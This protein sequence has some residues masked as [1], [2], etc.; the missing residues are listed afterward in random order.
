[1]ATTNDDFSY[2][3]DTQPGDLRK[4]LEKALAD[5]KKVRDELQTLQTEKR[6]G[7]V[8]KLLKEKGAPPGA[9]KFYSGDVSE[10]AVAAWLEENKDTFPIT[11]PTDATTQT[12]ATTTGQQVQ[13]Q[14][15]LNALAAQLLAQATAAGDS[16]DFGAQVGAFQGA[17]V[18]DPAQI[19]QMEQVLRSLPN[20]AEGYAQGVKLGI[21]PANPHQI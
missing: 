5:R 16:G 9:A 21:F 7:E 11:P 15:D 8:A 4:L 6:S 10:A 12:T 1:M 17:P 2:D 20:T 13:A 18:S 19:A 3:D 14:P